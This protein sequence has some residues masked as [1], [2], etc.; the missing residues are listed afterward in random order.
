MK[1]KPIWCSIGHWRDSSSHNVRFGVMW[2]S[3]VLRGAGGKYPY[4]KHVWS[5]SG[6]WWGENP[7]W[8]RNTAIAVVG[9][10]IVSYPVF[11][12]SASLEIRPN[13]PKAPIPSA[14]W[15][16]HKPGYDPRSDPKRD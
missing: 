2:A 16:K 4:P 8:M 5:P 15:V 6:G 3:R 9:M 12:L 14:L 10:V 1:I 11:K 7:N 13:E